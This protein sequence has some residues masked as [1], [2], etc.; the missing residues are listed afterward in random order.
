VACC[1]FLVAF[2]YAAADV[3]LPLWATH[4]LG[5]DAADWARLRSLRFAG[6]GVILLGAVSDR[7]GPRRCAAGALLASGLVTALFRLNSRTVLWAL[8]PVFGALVS[9]AMINLNTLTQAVS[10]TRPGVANTVYRSVGAGAAIMAPVAATFLAV[11]WGGYPAVFLLLALLSALGAWVLLAYPAA[12]PVRP[13]GHPWQELR[14][15]WRGYAGALREKPLMRYL[16]LSQVWFSSLGCVGGFAAIRLTRELGLSDRAFG[17]LSTCCGVLTFALIAG[18][19][20]CLDRM[21][22][23]R[24]HVGAGVVA[25][26]GALLMGASDSPWLTAAGMLVATP[27]STV[28]IAPASMWVS[29]A[30]GGASQVAAFAV[31]KVI[32]ALYLST[33]MFLFGVLE[34]RLGIRGVLLLGG[35]VGL[36]TALGF[37]WLPEPP[38]LRGPG[39]SGVVAC[40]P[41]GPGGYTTTADSLARPRAAT[42]EGER[43]RPNAE[44]RTP[45]AER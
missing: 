36:C 34:S 38:C 18:T 23:R 45:N 39:P 35:G 11:A 33:A 41:P 44:R 14:G 22:L 21:S 28:L 24:L 7:L 31:H 4:D 20:L 9:T 37:L 40:P 26:A 10:A 42:Q 43:S 12:E 3:V 19:G 29:Q 25:A 15:M 2:C 32:T 30:A 16:H 17:V 13:F 1:G 5:L 6:V 27:C 8:M